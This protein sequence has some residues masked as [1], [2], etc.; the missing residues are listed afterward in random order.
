[1]RAPTFR[2]LALEAP[3]AVEAGH[4]GH[5]DFRLCGRIFATLPIDEDFG[6]VNLTTE[7]QEALV[8]RYPEQF[9]PLAGS[10]GERGWT[11]VRFPAARAG[12]VREALRAACEKVTPR[13]SGTRA[14][15]RRHR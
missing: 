15:P 11:R 8:A 7:A 14:R 2:R 13:R 9:E 4:M 12:P 5:P 3:G 6:V 10:W 1:M